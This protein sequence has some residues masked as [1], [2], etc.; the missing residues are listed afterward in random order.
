MALI[1][2]EHQPEANKPSAHLQVVLAAR[3]G[4]HPAGL[5]AVERRGRRRNNFIA[6]QLQIQSI[7]A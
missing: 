5:L 1:F 2:H 7:C 6:G 4:V 3:L